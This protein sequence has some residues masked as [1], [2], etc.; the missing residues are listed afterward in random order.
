MAVDPFTSGGQLFFGAGGADAFG[1]NPAQAYASAYQAALKVNQQNYNNILKGYQVALRQQQKMTRGITQG[2][3]QLS[4]QVLSDIQGID[5]SQRQAIAD[6]YAQQSGSAAQS[7]ISR[8]LGNTTVQDSIQRGLALDKAKADVAL[9]NQT[10]QLQAGY[11]SQLG[12]AGLGYR[13]LAQQQRAALQNQQLGFMGSVQAQ[14][15]DAGLYAQMLS[16]QRGMAAG[17]F[18]PG[19]YVTHEQPAS[20][21]GRDML[22]SNALSLGGYG[23]MTPE[24]N[25]SMSI[26]GGSYGPGTGVGSPIFKSQPEANPWEFAPGSE[27]ANPVAGYTYDWSAGE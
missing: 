15:P 5:A 17:M 22:G 8:G 10:A 23:G 12:M 6:A 24:Q 16:Q 13:N 3:G 4:G 25:Y 9:S 1:S 14:Y 2:Y 11:R 26:G 19:S 18:G 21:A 27:Y 7:L 20:Q